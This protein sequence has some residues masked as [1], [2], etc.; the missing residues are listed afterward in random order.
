[1]IAVATSMLIEAVQRP[2]TVGRLVFD[3]PI[4]PT[5]DGCLSFSVAATIANQLLTRG[6]AS[7]TESSRLHESLHSAGQSRRIGHPCRGAGGPSGTSTRAEAGR[8]RDVGWGGRRHVFHSDRFGWIYQPRYSDAFN[9]GH[10][11]AE[12]LA[13]I[14]PA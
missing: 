7:T 3:E 5:S 6:R 10:V 2:V 4:Q 12:C 14:E 1:A 13:G 9:P 8:G 11:V